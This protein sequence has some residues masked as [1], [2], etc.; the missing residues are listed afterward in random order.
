MD[1][2]ERGFLGWVEDWVSFGQVT[3]GSGFL[4]LLGWVHMKC[5]LQQVV[6]TG[7]HPGSRHP[8]AIGTAEH[9]SYPKVDDGGRME[10][11]RQVKSSTAE[12][13]TGLQFSIA[14]PVL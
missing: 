12:D 11:A 9:Q 14:T 10:A 4:H 8:S 5:E 7:W 2:V 3:G 13:G 1:W 6:A